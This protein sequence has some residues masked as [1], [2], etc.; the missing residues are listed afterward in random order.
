MSTK[1]TVA[2]VAHE[3]VLTRLINVPRDKLFRC[4]IE[5][6]L[7]TQWFTPPPWKTIAAEIDLRTGGSSLITMQ[8]PDGTQ[9]PNHGVYLQVVKNERIVFTDAYICAWVP[10]TKPFFT[11]ILTFEDE[12]GQTRYTARARHW[13]AEDRAAH[14]KMGFHEGWGI[15]TNQLA[16]LAATL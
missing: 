11:C 7:I 12:G 8:G 14:E 9:I 6:A 2:N 1:A 13:T 4:W 5:P 15:A 3:L 10:S 16:A